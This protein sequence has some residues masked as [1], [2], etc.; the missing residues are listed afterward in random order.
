MLKLEC[1]T[2]LIYPD[3]EEVGWIAHCLEYDLLAHGRHSR[4]AIGRL[5]GVMATHVK[6]LVENH[7]LEQLHHPAPK[8]YWAMLRKAKP[9]GLIHLDRTT[10]SAKL[11]Q[12]L[13]KS[14]PPIHEM[15]RLNIEHQSLH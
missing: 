5:V 10:S 3:E 11:D 1:L 14:V 2:I 13:K 6:Y 15:A 4:E 9:M 12:L 8:H 7:R